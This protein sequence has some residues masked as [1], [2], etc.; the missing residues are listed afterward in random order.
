[1]S[2]DRATAPA[3]ARTVGALVGLVRCATTLAVGAVAVAGFGVAFGMG[4]EERR[5]CVTASGKE[6]RPRVRLGACKPCRQVFDHRRFQRSDDGEC[7]CCD[8]IVGHG[9][10]LTAAVGR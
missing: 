1:M 10:R 3:E 8:G 7:G 4:R 6:F 9:A 5:G 2:P